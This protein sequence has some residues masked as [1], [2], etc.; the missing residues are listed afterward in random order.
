[1][2]FYHIAS[3]QIFENGTILISNGSFFQVKDS[4]QLDHFKFL[5]MNFLM[6]ETIKKQFFKTRFL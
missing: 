2:L 4:L 3:Y 5:K 6:A 1:M